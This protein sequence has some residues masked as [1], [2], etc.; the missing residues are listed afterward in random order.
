[1]AS[2]KKKNPKEKNKGGRPPLWQNP[3]V[4]KKLVDNFFENEKHP[5]LAG[6]AYAL[7]CSRASL[8]NYEKK[9]EFLDIIKEARSRVELKYEQRLVYDNNATGV[10]FA[11]KN[12][13][14]ADR[15]ETDITSKGKELPAP[16]LGGISK[17]DVSSDNSDKEDK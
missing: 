4:L 17:Q 5:T 6:L 11:L 16:I 10:I 3:T 14:W 13:G 2:K 9:D 8:Y 12:M 1:M 7:G 15:R